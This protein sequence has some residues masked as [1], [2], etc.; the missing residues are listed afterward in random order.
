MYPCSSLNTIC[1]SPVRLS[2]IIELSARATNTVSLTVAA[3]TGTS[4]GLRPSAP[5]AY[6]PLELDPL[7]ERISEPDSA[8][9]V[10]PQ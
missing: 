3:L 4:T 5:S 1:K 8:L 10:Y 7:S 9:Y 6:I 2:P